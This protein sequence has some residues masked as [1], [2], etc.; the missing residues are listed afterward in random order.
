MDDFIGL[1]DWPTA[2]TNGQFIVHVEKSVKV[3]F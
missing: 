3:L 1:T 2:M